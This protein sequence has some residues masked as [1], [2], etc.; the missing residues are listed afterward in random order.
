MSGCDHDHGDQL[1]SQLELVQVCIEALGEVVNAIQIEDPEDNDAETITRVKMHNSMMA[2]LVACRSI[3]G[4]LDM[5][6]E[7]FARHCA[8]AITFAENHVVTAKLQEMK[9]H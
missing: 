5:D 2:M 6:D 7:E 8:S 3:G 4:G 1:K 9:I